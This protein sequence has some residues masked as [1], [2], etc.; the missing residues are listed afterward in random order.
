MWET[1][2]TRLQA[3][4]ASIVLKTILTDKTKDKVVTHLNSKLDIPILDEDD[5]R[6]L[7][8]LM[9]ESAELAI[10]ESVGLEEKSEGE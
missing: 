9:W 5:E 8:E 7:I 6:E 10:R 2:S 4:L 3:L 1:L